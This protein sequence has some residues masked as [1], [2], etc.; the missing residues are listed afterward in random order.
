M[1]VEQQS[2]LAAALAYAARG[3]AVLPVNHGGKDPL[4]AHGVK[5]ATRD[6]AQIRAPT[7]RSR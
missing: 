4:T 5:D 7:H 1:A 2:C 6:E 3:W